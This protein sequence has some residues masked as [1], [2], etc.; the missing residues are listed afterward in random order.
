M[1]IK[2]WIELK[3][4]S[5]FLSILFW[6]ILYLFLLK[7]FDKNVNIF[8]YKLKDFYIKYT[9]Y[10][11]IIFAIFSLILFYILFFLKFIFRLK[12]FIF[13][14]IIYFLSFWFF[15]IFGIDL[16]FFES[17]DANFAKI[18]INTFAI[19]LISSSSIILFI[20]LLLS[21]KNYKVK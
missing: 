10:S 3:K 2:K 15:L 13:T 5:F 6:I 7:Y 12:S 9:M 1:E 8:N 11:P 18:I 20:V 4:N 16:L 21:L 19:P 17:K 14:S